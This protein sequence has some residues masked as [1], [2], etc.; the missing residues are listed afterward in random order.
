MINVGRAMRHGACW[1]SVPVVRKQAGA[2]FW[3]GASR[4]IAMRR[5]LGEAR[6]MKAVL[7]FLVFAAAWLTAVA[8]FSAPAAANP[9]YAAFVMHAD[10]GDVLFARYADERRYPASLT[11]MMT[12]YLLFEELEAGRLTMN[13]ELSVSSQAAGQ[14]PSKLGLTA[15]SNIKVEEAIDALIV[16][17]ANDVAVVVAESISGSEWRF[18]QKMTERAHQLGMRRTT[19]RNAS[20]LPNSKQTT[21]ARD[22]A[23][24]GR[25]LVQDFPQYYPYFSTESFTWNGRVYRTHNRLIKTFEGAE[26]LKTGYTRRS[27]FNLVTSANREGNRL[28][29]V[30]LGGRSVGT[31]DAHMREILNNAYAEI[32]RN[33]TMLAALYR[34]APTPRLKPTLLAELQRKESAPTI[35]GD[36]AMQNDIFAASADFANSGGDDAIGALI[37]ASNSGDLN[38]YEL[39]RLAALTP[40]DGAIGEG[41]ADVINA[42]WSVQIGAY[43]SKPRAQ[44]ELELAAAAAGL[45]AYARAVQPVERASGG[46]LYRARFTSMTAVEAADLC[47]TLRGA[48]I[49]C[50]IAAES[51]AQ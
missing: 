27:G 35:A 38:E 28:I 26:G 3:G 24:L 7:R 23:T 15:G 30:V 46:A 6:A 42:D 39:V 17:S 41:D 49:T 12:L 40:G 37:A 29:G 1:G 20:G 5:R 21:T 9:N 25:R 32:G 51:S 18:A 8:A 2:S 48:K 4:H 16:K 13:S 47:Q 22:L 14:P 33:P 34:E 19:F 10:S 36:E 43:S 11:K 45:T 50:F 31:R 44:K